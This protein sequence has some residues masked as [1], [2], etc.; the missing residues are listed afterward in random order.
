MRWE[1]TTE[2]P[3]I[4]GDTGTDLVLYSFDDAG[5]LIDEILRINRSTGV[6]KLN[7][8]YELPNFDGTVGQV[9]TTDG[10][11]VATWQSV[12][13]NG[14]GNVVTASSQWSK[15]L[16]APVSLLNGSIANGFTFFDNIIDKVANGTTPYYEFNIDYGI[17]IQLSG[18][19]GSANINVNGVNY[20][21]TYTVS[22]F[23]TA[24][25]WVNANKATLNALGINVF[26][27]GISATDGRIRFGSPNET[28]LN[29]ITITNVVSNLSG[30]LSNEFTG[31]PNAKNDHIR[32]Q[33]NGEPID[34]QRLLH[35]IR[36]N[37]NISIGSVQYAE[38]RLYRYAD[39]SVIG[40]GVTIQRNPDETGQQVVIETYTGGALDAFV[41]GGF[42][43]GLAN[44]TGTTLDFINSAGILIQTVFQKPTLF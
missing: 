10:A 42:Y 39:N 11:G 16:P 26:A 43:I 25:N 17:T 34:G 30:V 18:T 38:L 3:E 44:N 1:L 41:T 27:L 40:S 9:L 13:G 35:T 22:L 24:L 32:V 23:Q 36:A 4:G 7:N 5:I 28:L 14:I 31:L 33:Y 37:F 8:A 15:T 19:S 29:N 12:G 20:L 21:A 6:I 2:I